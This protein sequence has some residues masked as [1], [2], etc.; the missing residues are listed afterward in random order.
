MKYMVGIVLGLILCA[1]AD[2]Q[3]R[4]IDVLFGNILELISEEDADLEEVAAVYERLARTPLDLNRAARGQLEELFV[5]NDFQIESLLAY[6]RDFG[7]LFSYDELQYIDGFDKRLADILRP[8]LT[9]IYSE[10]LKTITLHGFLNDSRRD[11]QLR[12]KRVLNRQAGYMPVTAEELESKPDSR[13]LSGPQYCYVR[14]ENNFDNRLLFN[15]TAESDP[16]EPFLYGNGK[17]G[18][19]FLSFSLRYSGEGVVK[20]LIIGDFKAGFGQG[21]VFRNSFNPVSMQSDPHKLRLGEG[22][23][24]EYLSSGEFEFLRGMA[25]TLVH[26]GLRLNCALSLRSL[27]AR[28]EDGRIVT[29]YETG[30]HNTSGRLR[31]RSTL[32]EGV[33]I[34]NASTEFRRV[35]TGITAALCEYDVEGRLRGNFGGDFLWAAPVAR[36]FGEVAAD[37]SGNLALIAGASGRLPRDFNCGLLLRSYSAGYEAPHA[38]PYSRNT[39]P[40]AEQGLK[41]SISHGRFG[42]RKL[43]LSLDYTWFTRPRYRISVPA[44]QTDLRAEL[45]D[46]RNRRA[47]CTLR[48]TYR[49]RLYDLKPD[50]N[51]IL[52]EP[53]DKFALRLSVRSETG[54]RFTFIHRGDLTLY[55]RTTTPLTT[56][57]ELYH[58]TVYTTKQE[59]FRLNARLAWFCTEEWD[60]RI[61]LSE[62]DIAPLYSQVLYGRG[63]RGYLHL[64]WNLTNAL[65]LRMK[66]SCTRYTDRDKTGEGLTLSEGPS[67]YEFK[68]LLNYRF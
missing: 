9:V 19:D 18:P 6:R 22:G 2:G 52:A 46:E 67:R 30:E 59:R 49:H 66:C 11:L 20:N 24:R 1:G 8:F 21:L 37:L 29:I 27:D 16:G 61:Y 13:Y 14:F 33:A 55:K 28:I 58:E 41:L 12:T 26:G 56:G 57:Y 32:Q 38:S 43:F 17:A 35:R 3:E 50:S 7:P 40:R 62:P 10:N 15:V 25:V 60:N 54:D 23:F 42:G 68:M 65:K 63:L 45:T 51:T 34:L 44:G 31:Y 36:L 5:L 53:H 48:F 4:E 64:N 39:Q 47:A